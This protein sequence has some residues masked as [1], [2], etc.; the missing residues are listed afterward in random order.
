MRNIKHARVENRDPELRA[1]R[2]LSVN[3]GVGTC[4]G[5]KQEFVPEGVSWMYLFEM[6]AGVRKARGV[7]EHIDVVRP[8]LRLPVDTFDDNLLRAFISKQ[9]PFMQFSSNVIHTFVVPEDPLGDCLSD[10][11]D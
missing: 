10:F 6:W 1:A 2:Y 7:G 4:T 11:S 5:G 3:L 8:F 9:E